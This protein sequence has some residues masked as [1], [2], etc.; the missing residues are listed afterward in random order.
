MVSRSASNSHPLVRFSLIVV[1]LGVIAAVAQPPHS[2]DQVI[3]ES[4][5]RQTIVTDCADIHC[6]R[7][8]PAPLVGRLPGPSL[9]KWRAY[10]VVTNAAAAVALGA[11]CL[12]LGLSPRASGFATWIAALGRGPMQSV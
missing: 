1:V 7:I 6:F 2:S 3:Y 5:G 9:V 4:I 10:A 8:L 12:V 11:L